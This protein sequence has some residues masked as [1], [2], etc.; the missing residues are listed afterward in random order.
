MANLEAELLIEAGR[1]YDLQNSSREIQRSG[2]GPQRRALQPRAR[3]AQRL[4]HG[5][6][7]E[8]RRVLKLASDAERYAFVRW[9]A[10]DVVIVDQHR[11]CGAFAAIAAATH[12]RGFA[13]P[14]RP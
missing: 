1:L 10:F 13:G 9:L 8:R 3:D 5:Q 6:R 12:G 14:V 4:G 2:A 7:I 11:S